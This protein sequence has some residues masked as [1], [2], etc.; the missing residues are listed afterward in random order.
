MQGDV[1]LS[2]LSDKSRLRILAS[3]TERPKFV[4]ELSL[5]LNISVST[6][7]FHLKKLLAADLVVSK[8]EQYYQTYSIRDEVLREDL[9]R[10][11]KSLIPDKDLFMESV[12]RECFTGGRVTNLPVQVRKRQAIYTIISE[13]FVKRSGYSEGE[14]SLIIAERCED[15]MTAKEEMLKL[16]YLVKNGDRIYKNKAI[17]RL[18]P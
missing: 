4:E 5:E 14:A 15:F 12:R 18:S 11:L 2:A 16:G 9:A 10:L 7:S 13:D 8:R 1:L 17:S 6:V 3:L